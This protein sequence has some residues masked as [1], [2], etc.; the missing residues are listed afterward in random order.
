MQRQGHLHVHELRLVLLGQLD[1]V[2]PQVLL[3][4]VRQRSRVL[5]LHH[6]IERLLPLELDYPGLPHHRPTGEAIHHLQLTLGGV[7]GSSLLL[8]TFCGDRGRICGLHVA[9]LD[10]V[11]DAVLDHKIAYLVGR[12]QNSGL[13]CAAT[14][15]SLIRVQGAAQR[16]RGLAKLVRNQLAEEGY[17][18]GSANDLH[19]VDVLHRQACFFHNPVQNA[20]DLVHEGLARFLHIRSKAI[21]VQILILHQALNVHIALRDCGQYLL[22]LLD[23]ILEL[24]PSF[25][26]L[27][28]ITARLLLEGL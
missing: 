16:L 8:H 7:S 11:G 1:A 27:D 20:L 21:H 26:V 22:H 17:S 14:G 4:A 28:R 25:G 15:N 23:P 10:T 3:H 13:Q 2:G 24:E 19:E 18:A 6:N 12:A 5:V 9:H